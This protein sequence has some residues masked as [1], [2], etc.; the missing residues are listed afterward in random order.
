M[1]IAVIAT[2]LAGNDG[3]TL[4]TKHWKKI[5]RQ[6]GHTVEFIAGQLDVSGTLIPRLH[7]QHPQAAALY[8]KVVYGGSDFAG[9]EEEI[10]SQAGIIE[11]SLRKVLKR[12]KPDLLV[13][14]NVLSLPMH[15]AF[16]VALARVIEDLKIPTIARHHDFWWERERFLKS[17]MFPFFQRFFPPLL[18]SIKH[19]VINTPAQKEFETRTGISAKII[20]DTAD[21]SAKHNRLDSYSRHFREDFGLAPDDHVFLQATRIVPR[22]RIELAIELV[23]KLND[24]KAVLVVAGRAGDEGIE[25][26][27]Y[28]RALAKKSSAR[29]KFIGRYVNAHR[30]VVEYK[31]RDG[32]RQQRRI[33]TLWDCYPNADF[34][35]YPTQLEGFGNQFVEAMYFKKPIVVTP[36]LIYRTD[37][38][39]LGFKAIEMP[40]KVTPE[41]IQKVRHWLDHPQEV[42]AITARNFALG[43]T[44]L[45]YTWTKQ[46]I[47][48]LFSQMGLTTV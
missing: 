48:E 32:K 2:R 18:P 20:W 22:K 16:A 33:Y 45:S 43:K 24:P 29:V 44:Y 46:K 40:D 4:E 19:V 41:T 30:R 15:F 39:P 13:V 14:P 35:T 17:S 8:K 42:T 9:V 5:L 7:F 27:R 25:Y 6:M 34:I 38:K 31:T 12:L 10:F 21:F 3:V 37:I 47:T 36:Y 23:E 26:E 28:L 1:K 11:G